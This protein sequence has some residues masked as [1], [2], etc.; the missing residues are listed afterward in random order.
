MNKKTSG[1][2]KSGDIIK[3]TYTIECLIGVG[4][5]GEVYRVKHKFLGRQALKIIKIDNF[6]DLNINELANEAVILSRLLHPNII[7]IF[8]ANTFRHG[9]KDY[10][11]IVMELVPGETLLKLIKR[12]IRLA[13]DLALSI[14]RDICAALSVVHN[15]SPPIVHG[16]VKPSNVI[17][18][19]EKTMPEAKLS[20]FGVARTL[21]PV[22]QRTKAGGTIYYLPSEAFWGLNSPA[23]DVFS[24]GIILYQMLTGMFPWV[25]TL[26]D[27]E[28]IEEI[29]SAILKARKNQPVKPSYLNEEIDEQLDDIILK[30]ISNDPD[31][32][33]KNGSEFLNALIEYEN[34]LNKPKSEN[35]DF[36]KS[37]EA[38]SLIDKK[39]FPGVAGMEEL[40][41]VLYSEI[42]LPLQQKELYEKYKIQ[43]PNGILL[44]GPPGCGKTFIAKKLSEEINYTFVEVKPSDLASIY[45]HGTQQK[46][47]E[48]FKKAKEQA[49]SILFFDEIDAM[50]PSR[51][52]DLSHHYSSE[53]NEFLTQLNECGKNNIV[54]IATTNRPDRIDPAALRTGRF[55]K[56]IYVP[57]PDFQARMALFNLFLCERPVSYQINIRE[58]AELTEGYASSDIEIIVN[59]AARQALKL[60]SEI[61]QN[62]LIESIKNRPSSIDKESLEFYENFKSR[63][64]L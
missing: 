38:K 6:D 1:L 23:G 39:G 8:E 47:A 64:K 54:V 52:N 2:L 12:K 44:Y 10:F 37:F 48:L 58:L 26:S 13:P 34:R 28:D 56:L 61:T 5:F 32:R 16:D 15:Q 25:M 36:S 45:V 31:K 62:I 60:N 63:Y 49:P 55:D 29:K 9:G 22:S 3:D 18:S 42:I 40:K 53:V 57:P 33:Y 20:D 30:A 17:I 51:Q 7:R 27:E 43:L 14:Q 21:N 24:A 41:E 35:I 46:I 11:Y 59:D 50:I 4:A 19:Y